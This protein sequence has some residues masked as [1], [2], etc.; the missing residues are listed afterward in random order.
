MHVKDS[1]Q[2]HIAPSRNDDVTSPEDSPDIDTCVE[3]FLSNLMVYELGI[4]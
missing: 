2:R 1:E 4:F 3:P